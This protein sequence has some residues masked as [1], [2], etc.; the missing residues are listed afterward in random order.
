MLFWDTES[1]FVFWCEGQQCHSQSDDEQEDDH[2]I[3]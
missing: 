3:R 2:P 1:A